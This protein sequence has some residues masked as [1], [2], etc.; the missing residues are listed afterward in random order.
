MD[1]STIN[2]N[3]PELGLIT[4]GYIAVVAVHDGGV[5]LGMILQDAWIILDLCEKYEVARHTLGMKQE[6]MRFGQSMV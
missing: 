3:F 4:R 2:G 6:K 5:W 1:K